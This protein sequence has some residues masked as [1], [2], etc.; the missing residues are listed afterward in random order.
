MD[1]GSIYMESE[2]RH[3]GIIYRF[4]NDD[5]IFG[6]IKLP[7]GT[8][9]KALARAIEEYEARNTKEDR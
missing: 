5:N 2:E 1:Q 9:L 3:D 8:H 6:F 4:Y 7:K